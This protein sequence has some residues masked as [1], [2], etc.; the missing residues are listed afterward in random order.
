VDCANTLLKVV[1]DQE[2][3]IKY[4]TEKDEPQV[5]PGFDRAGR[6]IPAATCSASER[7]LMGFAIQ[8]GLACQRNVANEQAGFNPLILDNAERIQAED[9]VTLV[10]Y[11]CG[12][13]EGAPQVFIAGVD[14]DVKLGDL[15]E[16]PRFRMVEVGA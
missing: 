13:P 12:D 5:E 7:A 14:L 15:Q 9:L 8:Y 6:F 10:S 1:L 16:S 2:M 3:G 11:L 4:L